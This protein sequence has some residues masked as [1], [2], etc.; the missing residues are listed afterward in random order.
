MLTLDE[1]LYQFNIDKI[2]KS[3]AKFDVG[4]LEYLNSMHIR[5]K[6]AYID[7]NMEEAYQCVTRWRGM[8]L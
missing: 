5:D 3:G 1:M 8:L 6:F 2:S 4:K 7:G